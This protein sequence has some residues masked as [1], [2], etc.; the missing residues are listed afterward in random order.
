MPGSPGVYFSLCRRYL[1]LRYP[2]CETMPSFYMRLPSCP[3]LRPALR[4]S[5]LAVACGPFPTSTG[6]PCLATVP[7]SLYPQSVFFKGTVLSVPAVRI[8]QRHSPVC[9]RSLS[10]MKWAI[11][12]TVI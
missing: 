1:Q 3:C 7:S 2:P 10:L 8:S 11:L 9:V 12:V 5:R 6:G 4:L